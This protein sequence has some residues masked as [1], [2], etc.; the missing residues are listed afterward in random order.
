MK[1]LVLKFEFK[2]DRNYVH[3]SD[4]FVK[5][6][7]E[8]CARGF[9]NWNYMELNIKQICHNNLICFLSERKNNHENEVINFTIKKGKDRI[10]GTIL[11]DPEDK[12]ESRYSF[13]DE[14]IFENCTINYE[15]GSITYDNPENTFLTIEIILASAKFF[16]E[17]AMDNSVKWYFRRIKLLRPI[18]E[19]ETHPI[20]LKKVSEKNGFIGFDLFI[21]DKQFG[22]GYAAAAIIP[23][24]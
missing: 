13:T 10:F 24:L 19:I 23:A 7:D 16:L 20:T 5:I 8:M 2:G 18:E 12:I 15:E 9:D 11:E 6:V 14:D 22:D 3:G 1:E 17:N 4:V 21:G